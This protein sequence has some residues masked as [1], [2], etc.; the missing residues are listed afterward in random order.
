MAITTS[1][2]TL[3]AGQVSYGSCSGWA[4]RPA[5]GWPR[6]GFDFLIIE[7]ERRAAWP[8]C[9]DLQA[10]NGT[11][12][13]PSCGAWNDPVAVKVALDVASRGSGSP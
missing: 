12:P 13:S 2:A 7:G 3:A 1:Q 9:S 6:M 4:A 11:I 10:M 5:E 8:W